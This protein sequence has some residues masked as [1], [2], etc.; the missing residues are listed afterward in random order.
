MSD[1]KFVDELDKAAETTQLGDRYGGDTIGGGIKP[2][3]NPGKLAALQEINGTH[4]IA[5]GKKAQREVGFGFDIVPHPRAD[6]PE[7]GGEGF[8]T[9]DSFWNGRDS[10]WRIGPEGT[11]TA[12]PTEVFELSRRDYYGIG[13]LALELLYGDDGVP[14]GLAHLPAKTV[15]KRKDGSGAGYGY[16][17]ERKGETR[18]FGEAPDRATGDQYVDAESGDTADSV[19]NVSTPAN[20]LIFVPNP[21]PISLWY[22]VPDWVAE[23]P[24]MMADKAA[25]EFNGDFFEYDAIPQFLVIVEGGTLSE[26]A[27]EDVRNMITKMRE[28]EGRRVPVLD[29]EELADHGVDIDKDVEIRIE[30]I[31]R[32]GDEDMAFSEFRKLNEHDVAKVHEVPPQLVGVMADSNRS[33]IKE[34]I[35]D[36]TKEVIEPAQER[37]SNRL[38]R[39]IHQQALQVDDW[40]LEFET[41]GAENKRENAE[42]AATVV[43]SVGQ[44]MTVREVRSEHGLTPQPEWMSDDLANT[45]LSELSAPQGP[46]ATFEQIIE[47]TEERART[48]ARTEARLAR[49]HGD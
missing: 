1:V 17:Q 36:F 15:R 32:Q 10:V 4:A 37:F 34:A 28:K 33:N 41:R 29:A 39:V 24:T 40:T 3:Y 12:T 21:S 42:V 20:D 18:Y 25:K 13:W 16:V 47:E 26:D 2:P 19:G 31:T 23:I 6:N 14:Q 48:Q 5:I 7:R 35:R 8:D 27:R 22:G 49:G 44:A 30:T 9:V 11:S 43:D 38:Y 46:G 45:L